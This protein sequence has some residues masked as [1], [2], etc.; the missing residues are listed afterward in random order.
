MKTSELK[1]YPECSQKKTGYVDDKS[2]PYDCGQ[3]LECR[4]NIQMIREEML[5]QRLG[6]IYH[7]ALGR[8]VG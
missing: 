1:G 4:E 7:K 8:Y 6:I 3:C 2:Y 5:M